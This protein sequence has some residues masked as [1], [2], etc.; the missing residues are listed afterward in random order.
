MKNVLL[1]VSVLAFVPSVC[2]MQDVSVE[3]G[4]VMRNEAV[5]VQEPAQEVAAAPAAAVA[6]APVQEVPVVPAPI[7]QEVAAVQVSAIQMEQVLNLIKN[8]TA[9]KVSAAIA[10]GLTIEE[11]SRQVFSI[12]A[13][14]SALLG[15]TI[16]ALVV[17]FPQVRDLANQLLAKKSVSAAHE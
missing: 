3:Q 8:P 7:Q 16:A 1:T 13:K 5:A 4:P 14:K 15:A 11:M 17:A 12:G 10:V 6:P 9:Q 2:A